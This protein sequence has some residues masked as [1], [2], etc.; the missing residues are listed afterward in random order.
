MIL[1][2]FE[3]FCEKVCVNKRLKVGNK[4]CQTNKYLFYSGGYTKVAC[5]ALK[6]LLFR[7]ESNFETVLYMQIC[8]VLVIVGCINFTSSYCMIANSFIL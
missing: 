4:N 3:F 2:P 5:A 6:Q 8:N 7:I 1:T